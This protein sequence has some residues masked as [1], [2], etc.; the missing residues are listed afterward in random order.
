MSHRA[1]KRWTVKTAHRPVTKGKLTI[2]DTEPKRVPYTAGTQP[3]RLVTEN[4]PTCP[5]W[6][7]CSWGWSENYRGFW[8]KFINAS[9]HHNR[10]ELTD[11]PR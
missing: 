8:L 4:P 9:C 5:E 11:V 1:G 7:M 2:V 6:A 3:N 10:K